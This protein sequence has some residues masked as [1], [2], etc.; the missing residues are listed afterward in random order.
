MLAHLPGTGC[1]NRQCSCWM[2]KAKYCICHAYVSSGFVAKYGPP[3]HPV[4]YHH[5]HPFS[6]WTASLL[7]ISQKKDQQNDPKTMVFRP[8]LDDSDVPHGLRNPQ[9]QRQQRHGSPA[10][11]SWALP[12]PNAE[13]V[14]GCCLGGGP[15]QD[16]CGKR[17][18]SVTA[19]TCGPEI[20]PWLEVK[21]R[22]IW[23]ISLLLDMI[24]QQIYSDISVKYIV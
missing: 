4:V 2:P 11:R 6:T 8:I 5:F 15:C 18:G 10:T 20:H 12:A 13:S 24:A 9:N 3:F 23:P 17:C 19:T 1:S 7:W 14:S 21:F 22:W 16:P